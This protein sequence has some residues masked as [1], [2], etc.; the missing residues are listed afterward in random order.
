MNQVEFLETLSSVY[1]A[2]NWQYVNNRF[3]GTGRRG[4]AKGSI[5]NP[6]TAVAYSVNGTYYENTKRGTQRAARSLGMTTQ[7][8]EPWTC[9]NCTR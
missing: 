3:V 1:G 7:L 8:A 5:F 2:Y 6:V 4:K 9:S